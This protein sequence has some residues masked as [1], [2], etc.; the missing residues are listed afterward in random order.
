M[1][2]AERG[3]LTK[4]PPLSRI[5]ATINLIVPEM[6]LTELRTAA[7]RSSSSLPAD[8]APHSVAPGL[9]RNRF[10][11]IGDQDQIVYDTFLSLVAIHGVS[12]PLVR[13]VMYFVWAW[14]DD[15]IRRFVVEEIADK[16]G[17]W[18]TQRAR[19]K[20]R[21]SFFAQFGGTPESAQKARSNYE[22][23]LSETGILSPAG[24]TL[25]PPDTWL[26]DAMLVA[27][28]H[29]PDP[30]VRAG[31]IHDPVGTL[32]QLGLNAVAD[33]TRADRS[34]I[35]IPSAVAGIVEEESDELLVTAPI[36]SS[37]ARDW[38]DRAVGTSP[39]SL[40]K[41][42]VLN[43]VALERAN[44]SHLLLERLFAKALASA[45]LKAQFTSSIDMICQSSDATI[46]CEMKSCT[47]RNFHAQIRRGVSQLL[48]YR[49]LY[50]QI[51][52][53]D[54]ALVMV[55]ESE[56][57]RKKRWLAEYLRSIGILLVWKQHGLDALV[58]DGPV[59]PALSKLVTTA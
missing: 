51:V 6:T 15:R 30:A 13:R 11:L 44:A 43:S 9:L 45:G 49:W 8:Q 10:L 1:P 16:S 52:P 55:V 17:R 23:F 2:S 36:T 35:V 21:A 27:A 24:V 33:L 38:K 40:P 58:M 19:D 25:R 34:S 48:E 12:S 4:E 42:I 5:D 37:D 3:S 59:P 54:A 47:A 20:K 18:S 53:A 28:Q 14:R 57:P 41:T 50:R 39:P 22:F 46:I 7:N 32:F 56:P 29:E 26:R 31:M